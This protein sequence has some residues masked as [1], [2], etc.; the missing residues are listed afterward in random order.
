MV[1]RAT[2]SC[3]YR[4]VTFL[5]ILCKTAQNGEHRVLTQTLFTVGWCIQGDEQQG[6]LHLGQEIQHLSHLTEASSFP[7]VCA[8]CPKWLEAKCKRD[9]LYLSFNNGHYSR[10]SDSFAI[11][12]SHIYDLTLH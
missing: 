5:P 11:V 9:F 10:C 12:G 7:I 3:N 2:F 1:W 8:V 6:T 4:C